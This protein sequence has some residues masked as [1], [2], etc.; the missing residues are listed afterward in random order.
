MNLYDKKFQIAV[1]PIAKIT[2][3]WRQRFTLKPVFILTKKEKDKRFMA[4]P[5]AVANKKITMLK[6]TLSF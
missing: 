4:K 5:T 2:E 1:T 3:I 6:M